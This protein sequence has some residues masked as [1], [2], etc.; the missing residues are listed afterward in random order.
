[1]RQ[2]VQSVSPLPQYL[3]HL[4]APR[5]LVDELVQVA[6]LTHQRILDLLDPDAADQAFDL[7]ARRVGDEGRS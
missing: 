5:Q 3:L 1:M 4:L 2:A 7:G 6:D